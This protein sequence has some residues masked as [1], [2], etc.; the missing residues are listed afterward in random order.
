MSP[1]TDEFL[2]A[3]DDKTVRFW[4]RRRPSRRGPS[5][6]TASS[7]DDSPAAPTPPARPRPSA[8]DLRTNVCAGVLRCGPAPCVTYDHQGLVLAAST[9]SGVVK[10]YDSRKYDQG[11]FDT[12]A[13]G[14]PPGPPIASLRF[15]LDGK[16]LLG[17]PPAA[18]AEAQGRRAAL[19]APRRGAARPL[20]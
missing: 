4:V 15:S 17:A 19:P 3:S 5:A 16:Q 9:D 13:V 2:S 8:Q 12:F 1:K 10:L 11:P 7:V 20:R 6:P 14:P 18:G